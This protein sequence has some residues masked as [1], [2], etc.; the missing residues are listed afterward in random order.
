MGELIKELERFGDLTSSFNLL[1][2]AV[3]F[4]LSL[5]LSLLI[6]WVYR[7]THRG[8]SYSQS[9]VHTLV[10]FG[11]VVAFIMLIVGSNIA[12]AFTLVGALSII[13]F[14]H[15]VKEPRDIGFVFV[16]MAIGMACGTRFYML[17][18]FATLALGAAILALQKLNLFAKVIR[19]RILI[20]RLPHDADY[21]KTFAG[22]FRK[23][24]DEF[25][26]ISM[27]TVG[28]AQ[29]QEAIYSVVLRPS[30]E[31]SRFLEAVREV[32]GNNKVSLVLGQQEIDL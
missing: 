11:M 21:E 18:V 2:V 12:R 9:Y 17:A 27:E 3:V 30:V 10:M 8:V 31:P 26:L 13:R 25:S 23:F 16:V 1:D 20:V 6:G 14:R 7:T 4:F 22:V 15:A 24:L 29:Y 19:E 28:E 5:V 32:N